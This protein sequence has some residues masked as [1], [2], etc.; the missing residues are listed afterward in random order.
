MLLD[1]FSRLVSGYARVVMGSVVCAA[2]VCRS[3]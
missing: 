1:L 3:L 2:R